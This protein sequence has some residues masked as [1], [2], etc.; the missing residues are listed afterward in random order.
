MSD[1][2]RVGPVYGGSGTAPPFTATYTGAQRTADAHG[3]FLQANLEGRLFSGGM[4][5]TSINNATFT[6]ATLGVTCT[7]IVGVWNPSSNDRYLMIL[8][9]TLQVIITA[10]QNTGGGTYMWATSTGNAVISTGNNPLN[11]KTL[12]TTGSAAKDMAGLAL[13][14]MTNNLVVRGAANLGGGSVYGGLSTLATAAGF[15]TT[16]APSVENVD[17]GLLVPPG[18]V[19]ALLCTSTPVACSAASGI[20]WEEIPIFT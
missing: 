2:Q 4:T 3:R 1:L 6:T 18:G 13:T 16:L 9:A 11:R 10:L 12:A 7:P 15:N 20:I 5:A 19:L 14:G 17:G 8:Q